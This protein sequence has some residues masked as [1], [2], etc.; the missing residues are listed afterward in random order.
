MTDDKLLTT[1][2]LGK[3]LGGISVRTLERWRSNGE[4]PAYIRVGRCVR[5]RAS[6]VAVYIAAN[7]HGGDEP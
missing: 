5:Y 6:D 7:M 3:Y 1:A 2:E 4:G